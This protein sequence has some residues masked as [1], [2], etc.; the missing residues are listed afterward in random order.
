M[1][2]PH[3]P[4]SIFTNDNGS[5]TSR[6]GTSPLNHLAGQN[7]MDLPGRKPVRT[8]NK[9]YKITTKIPIKTAQIPV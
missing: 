5:S 9:P 6:D 3:K 4:V 2:S 8:S 1:S 7:P